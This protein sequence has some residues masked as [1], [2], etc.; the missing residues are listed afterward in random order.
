MGREENR[1][2]C[3]I[4]HPIHVI[5]LLTSAAEAHGMQ[6]VQLHPSRQQSSLCSLRRSFDWVALVFFKPVFRGRIP[7]YWVQVA[8]GYAW[9]FQFG[10]AERCVLR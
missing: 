9:A 5:Y 2:E 1:G 4:C 3:I 7:F 6:P 8:Q 10:Q